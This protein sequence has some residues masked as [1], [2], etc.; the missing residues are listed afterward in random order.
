[1]WF[2]SC[3]HCLSPKWSS[4]RPADPE[5]LHPVRGVPR[6]LGRG[7]HAAVQVTR[8]RRGVAPPADRTEEC[9]G[10][11]RYQVPGSH[12]PGLWHGPGEWASAPSLEQT[13]PL[14]L[15]G[16]RGALPGARCL[17]IWRNAFWAPLNSGPMFLLLLGSREP[18]PH[19][20]LDGQLLAPGAGLGPAVCPSV[21]AGAACSS[22]FL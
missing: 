20:C 21:A 18:A 12:D 22:G 7:V 3:H 13:P 16:H 8:D 6:R 4:S 11:Q 15:R 10:G 2:V 1:M 9:Q 17:W 5:Q 14:G 19:P